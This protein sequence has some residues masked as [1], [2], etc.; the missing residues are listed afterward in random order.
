[1]PAAEAGRAA[2]AAPSSSTPAHERKVA[3]NIPATIA[4]LNEL[5][6]ISRD[7]E[8]G[9]RNGSEHASDPRLKLILAQRAV[10]CAQAV[11]E[12]RRAVFALGG[13]A[14]DSGSA[15]GA[16]QRGW[17]SVKAT[18]AI[19]S[20]REILEDAERDEDRALHRY[21]KIAR[22]DLNGDALA[23]VQRQL[24]GVRRNHDQIR[25]LHNAARAGQPIG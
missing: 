25:W 12:L 18:L 22:M 3:M 1:M 11:S 10:D 2:R 19:D 23:L 16:V 7:G 9:F 14:Q 20:D 8:E 13:M 24:E 21:E 5:I 17:A 6:G 15:L 4:A